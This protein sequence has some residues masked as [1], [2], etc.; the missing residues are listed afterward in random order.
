MNKSKKRDFGLEGIT[1]FMGFVYKILQWVGWRRGSLELPKCGIWLGGGCEPAGGMELILQELSAGLGGGQ[2][3]EVG[4][5]E[6]SVRAA[7][8]EDWTRVN[9]VAGRSPSAVHLECR[10]QN[11]GPVACWV[12]PWRTLLPSWSF[13]LPSHYLWKYFTWHFL[14]CFLFLEYHRIHSLEPEKLFSWLI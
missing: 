14:T 3:R 6:G 13:L 1:C 7:W 4:N 11:L 10:G 12:Q 5:R 2:Q 8:R 9:Y